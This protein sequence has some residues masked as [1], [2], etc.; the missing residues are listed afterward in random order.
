MEQQE[1]K[2]L[3]FFTE[4]S[5]T[6]VVLRV[7]SGVSF[8]GGLVIGLQDGDMEHASRYAATGLAFA[9]VAILEYRLRK[10]NEDDAQHQNIREEV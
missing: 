10:S 8:F 1:G 5:D 6:G 7:A 4:T 9:G 3:R 2:I